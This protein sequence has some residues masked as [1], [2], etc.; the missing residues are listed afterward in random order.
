MSNLEPFNDQ[1]ILDLSTNS[2]DRDKR[3]D[4][5]KSYVYDPTP[6]L[7]AD[8]KRKNYNYLSFFSMK[9]CLEISSNPNVFISNNG[10]MIN[11]NFEGIP[12]TG[13]LL[14]MDGIEHRKTRSIISS[15]FTR[16]SI[17]QLETLISSVV[18]QVFKDAIEKNSNGDIDF[19][20]DL[21]LLVPL[22]IN[23]KMMGV[24]EKDSFDILE[25]T[26]YVIGN[27]DP[28]YGD[29]DPMVW[30]KSCRKLRRQAIKLGRSKSGMGGDDITSRLLGEQGGS[31]GLDLE[32]FAQFFMLLVIAG[33]ETT[34][35]ALAH[36][37]K[38][39]SENPEERYKLSNNFDRYIEGACEEILRF[40]PPVL[41]FRRTCSEDTAVGD[42]E[43]KKGT[44]VAMWYNCVNRDPSIFYDSFNFKIDRELKPPHVTFGAPGV[45]HCIGAQL[46]RLEMKIFYKKL[47]ELMPDFN[48]DSNT[49]LYGK[50]RWG[51]GF[52]SCHGTWK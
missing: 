34:T 10:Y 36:G 4:V 38:L 41:Y 48:I 19:Y 42:T 39:L 30:L 46:A 27:D 24:P 21:C 50:S 44:R 16:S 6:R 31:V 11:D 43:I 9:D 12:F 7:F 22:E 20:N 5:F 18:D 2:P 25:L 51:N 47:F 29:G 8:H 1:W 13:S 35:H 26:K 52:R 14:S 15:V 49:I 17:M 37:I 28:R 32:D 45:H 23:R 40:E 33:M 3:W